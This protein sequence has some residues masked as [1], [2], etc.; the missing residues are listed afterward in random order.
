MKT[1]L[2]LPT[3]LAT[4]LLTAALSATA[5]DVAADGSA[6]AAAEA[7]AEASAPTEQ[8][9]ARYADLMGST[10]AATALIQRLRSNAEDG[11]AM[12]YGEIDNALALTRSAIES[13]AATSA[14]AALDTV[15]QL[16][17]DGMGWGQVAQELGVSLGDAVSTAH[18]VGTAAQAGGNADATLSLAGQTGVGT[19]AA[20][21]VG[22]GTAASVGVRAGA[23]RNAGANV[24]TRVDARIDAGLRGSVPDRPA[25]LSAPQLPQRLPLL[26]R[27]GRP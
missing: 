16:R 2:L 8:L 25:G 17:S 22:A 19:V 27:P 14:D 21:S 5:Q 20:G 10:E 3:V 26:S 15:L 13:G 24:N 12:G 23:D 6:N 18:G 1:K 4:S 7:F 9:A 11:A